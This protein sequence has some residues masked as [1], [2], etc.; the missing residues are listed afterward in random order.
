MDQRRSQRYSLQL[1]LEILQVGDARVSRVEQTRDISSGG[2]CFLSPAQVEVGG[3]IEY[4]ITLSDNNPPVRIRC[5]GKVL[6]SRP[7]A[8]DSVFEVAVTMDRYQFVRQEEHAD[9][10]PATGGYQRRPEP[11][12]A[13]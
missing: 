9:D 4:V 7:A 2:V 13:G 3:K 12:T 11:V 6:R 1:P 10:A 8:S 5:L